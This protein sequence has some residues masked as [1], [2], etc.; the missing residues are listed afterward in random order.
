[1]DLFIDK[2]YQLHS[3]SKIDYHQILFTGN[4][5]LPSGYTIVNGSGQTV[6]VTGASAPYA[7]VVFQDSGIDSVH[8]IKNSTGAYSEEF[9][10]SSKAK[11]F[12]L[13]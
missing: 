13:E 10:I 7:V 3:E 2:A 1:M 6:Y 11:K 12:V 8:I 9:K 5:T 4:G